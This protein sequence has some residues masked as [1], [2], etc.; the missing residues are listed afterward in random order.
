VRGLGGK[1]GAEA[2]AQGVHTPSPAGEEQHQWGRAPCLSFGDR[3]G[4][5]AVAVWGP[6]GTVAPL[7]RRWWCESRTVGCPWSCAGP[8]THAE[9]I[10]GRRARRIL[11]GATKH[12]GRVLRERSALGRTR[13]SGAAAYARPKRAPSRRRCPGGRP[14]TRTPLATLVLPYPLYMALY[15]LRYRL[16]VRSIILR[17]TCTRQDPS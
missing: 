13:G 5:K 17:D 2:G 1:Q 4:G 6:P 16:P 3:A 8:G 12:A 7:V 10:G 15:L 14:G 11:T 9:A